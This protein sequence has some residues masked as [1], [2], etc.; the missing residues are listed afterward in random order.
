MPWQHNSILQEG[1]SEE[2]TFW[3]SYSLPAAI[4]GE[5]LLMTKKGKYRNIDSCF[6]E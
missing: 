6:V 1:Q 4:L 5:G 3:P 2:D